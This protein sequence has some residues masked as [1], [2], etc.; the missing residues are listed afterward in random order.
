MNDDYERREQERT[1]QRRAERRKQQGGN[2]NPLRSSAFEFDDFDRGSYSL[3]HGFAGDPG[4]DAPG[5]HQPPVDAARHAAEFPES[6]ARSQRSRRGLGRSRRRGPVSQSDERLRI[7]VLARLASVHE[8]ADSHVEVESRAGSVTLRG[9]VR[10]QHERDRAEVCA[11][12]VAGVVR[13]LNQLGIEAAE[14]LRRDGKTGG[15]A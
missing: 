14:R 10:S 11:G 12:E 6:H 2:Q 8:L 5:L 1:A 9:S 3:N 7:S 15:A 4:V 13:V